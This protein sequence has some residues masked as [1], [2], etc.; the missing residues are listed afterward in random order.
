[1]AVYKPTYR[2]ENRQDEAAEIWW[3]HFTYAL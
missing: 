1:M 2:Q 3:Y